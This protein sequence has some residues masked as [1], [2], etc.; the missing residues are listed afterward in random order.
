MNALPPPQEMQKA[1]LSGDSSYDGI[2]FTGVRTTGIFCV[3]S[4]PAKKPHAQNVEFF[5]SVKDAMFAGYRPCKRCRPTGWSEAPDWVKKLLDRIEINPQARITDG[6]L[7]EMGFD[8]T[9]VRRFFSKHYGM[10]FQAYCRAKRLATALDTLRRGDD[11]DDVVFDSGYESHSGFRESF[12]KLFGA[13]PGEPEGAN[14]VRVGWIDTPL[15]PMI[16]GA[17]DGGVC[18]LEFTDRRMLE[19]Q[20]A[21]LRKRFRGGIAP[22][23]NAHLAKLRD[24]LGQYFAGRLKA[25]T[26]PMEYPGTDF[27]RRVWEALL[28]IPYGT[29]V[30]YEDL[31][32]TVGS[33]GAQRAVGTANGR[34]RIAIVIPCHRVV[35]KSGEL[36]GYG[37]GLWRKQR[38]LEIERGNGRLDFDQS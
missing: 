5:A 16:A 17:T 1:F 4:C 11:L 32:N 27:E 2:F 7:I 34:N 23:D 8:P 3:P 21:T 31:A 22:G 24:Q 28:R 25:F 38:L 36:G 13:T 15:G 6:D 35:N 37:G 19:A 14:C 10:T 20:F 29:T 33:P 18:L 12:G 9:R 30:S 26:V